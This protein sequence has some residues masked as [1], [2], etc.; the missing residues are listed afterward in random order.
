MQNTLQQNSSSNSH[1]DTRVNTS[2]NDFINER[3]VIQVQKQHSPIHIENPNENYVH[4][5]QQNLR[6][7]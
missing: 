2:K 3:K 6:N 7:N 1:Y 5:K 4:D